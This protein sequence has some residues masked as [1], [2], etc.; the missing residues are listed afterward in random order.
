MDPNGS[1]MKVVVDM[2]KFNVV[3]YMNG[4][5]FATARIQRHLRK[6]RLVA[7]VEINYPGDYM[8][9]N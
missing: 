1:E 7:Y 4:R 6:E 3:M 2:V 8:Y 9:W 5:E